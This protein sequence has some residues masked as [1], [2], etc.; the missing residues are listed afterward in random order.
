[1][2]VT[3]LNA[4]N[5]NSEAIQSDKTVLI[6]FYATWCGPCKMV[7]PI[8]DEIAEETNEY[9]VCKVDV[10][11]EP[12]LAQKFGVSSIPTLV[13]LKG[14]KIAAQSVGYRPKNEILTM[15]EK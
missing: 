13:V 9:K 11:D 3:K 12:E 5:F 14:G 8:I 10:D 2:S 6:D 15:L 4:S 7:S 1:M